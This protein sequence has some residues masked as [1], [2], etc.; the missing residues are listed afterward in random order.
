MPND[1]DYGDDMGGVYWKSSAS[2]TYHFLQTAFIPEFEEIAV[3]F[4]VVLGLLAVGRRARRR[5]AGSA[6]TRK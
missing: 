3:P 5:R 2:E 6:S 4:L 1:A